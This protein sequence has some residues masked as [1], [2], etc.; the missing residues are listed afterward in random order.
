[1]KSIEV[2]TEAMLE[3]IKYRKP[4]VLCTDDEIKEF[5][6]DLTEKEFHM[7]EAICAVYSM[8][9]ESLKEQQKN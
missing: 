8:K 4:N 9:L 6:F 3:R 1:M 7:V 5:I 2:I